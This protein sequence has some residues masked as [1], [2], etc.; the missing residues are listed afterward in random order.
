MSVS[1]PSTQLAFVTPCSAAARW[2]RASMSGSGSI[3][4]PACTWRAIG[5][6]G[7]PGPT[8]NVDDDV[9]AGQA[10]CAR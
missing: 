8:A 4:A 3:P 1:A 7:W 5:K 6:V 9:V 10:E 2:A